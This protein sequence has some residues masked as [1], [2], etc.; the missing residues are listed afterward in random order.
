VSIIPQIPKLQPSRNDRKD[1]G[2]RE[3]AYIGDR[4]K[5]TGVSSGEH[6]SLSPRKG[7]KSK[8]EEEF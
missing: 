3:E 4:A 5:A 1:E 8:K 6:L 7:K 2:D